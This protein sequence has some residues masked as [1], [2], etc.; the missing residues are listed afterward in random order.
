MTTSEKIAVMKASEEGK[1]IQIFDISS[2]KWV[3]LE[4]LTIAWDWMHNAYRIKPEPKL[5]PY[6]FEELC[7]AIVKHGGY[8]QDKISEYVYLISFIRGNEVMYVNGITEEFEKLA[9][10]NIW[11]DDKSPCGIMEE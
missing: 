2:N 5:R 3:D 6:T 10:H 9:E 8:V 1:N 7:E 11:L 4:N